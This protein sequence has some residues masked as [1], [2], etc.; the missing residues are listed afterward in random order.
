MKRAAPRRSVLRKGKVLAIVCA[1]LFLALVVYLLAFCFFDGRE[2]DGLVEGER[3]AQP[4]L[5]ELAPAGCEAADMSPI[6]LHVEGSY[7]EGECC[8]DDV[9]LDPARPE[10]IWLVPGSY[11]MT[12][13]T[14]PVLSDGSVYVDAIEQE[15]V[16]ES[17]LSNEAVRSEETEKGQTVT[18]G[19]RERRSPSELTDEQLKE[20]AEKFEEFGIERSY[21]EAIESS[22]QQAED[23]VGKDAEDS[24]GLESGTIVESTRTEDSAA[25][26][27][28]RAEDIVGYYEKQWPSEGAEYNPCYYVHIYSVND[29]EVT[30][31]VGKAARNISFVV[32]TSNPDDIIGTLDDDGLIHFSYTEDGWF[33]KGYGTIDVQGDELV[34]NVVATYTD[35]MARPG[36]TLDTNGPLTL[37]KTPFI[38]R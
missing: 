25:V 20:I 32:T 4:I 19:Y 31:T 17:G 7:D 21:L 38:Q 35:D 33:G 9:L 12:N 14:S 2:S 34:I 18:V 29:G 10:P 23:E 13:N 22:R 16:V 27:A 15:F 8:G 24:E 3:A 6:S 37:Q 30:L 11:R 26:K 28:V 1:G 5:V 36:A